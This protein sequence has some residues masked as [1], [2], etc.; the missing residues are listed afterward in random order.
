MYKIFKRNNENKMGRTTDNV[1]PVYIGVDEEEFDENKVKIEDDKDLAIKYE[2]Y[3]DK[4]IILYCC[5]ISIEK[6]PIL[7]LRILKKMLEKDKNVVLFVVGDDSEIAR[8]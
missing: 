1:M 3:K 5:R 4:K 8:Q 2:K 7:A 6:R